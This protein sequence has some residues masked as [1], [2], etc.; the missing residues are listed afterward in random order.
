MVNIEDDLSD[1]EFTEEDDDQTFKPN[2]LQKS[3]NTQQSK[4]NNDDVEQSEK[5]SQ[6]PINYVNFTNKG[7]TTN[8]NVK[9]KEEPY[10]QSYNKQNNNFNPNSNDINNYDNYEDLE[11]KHKSQKK[12]NIEYNPHN[13]YKI[14]YDLREDRNQYSHSNKKIKA[15]INEIKDERLN[16]D[17]L[18]NSDGDNSLKFSDEDK[19]YYN[20]S[21]HSNK[22]VDKKINPN[23]KFSYK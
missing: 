13:Q 4:L 7:K 15:S 9:N 21:I 6:K 10:S 11:P 20:H 5:Y 8:K 3:H 1:M 18:L 14:Q 2:K 22:D 23:S 17:D 12:S 16:E 19:E